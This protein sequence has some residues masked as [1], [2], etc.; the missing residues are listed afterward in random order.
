MPGVLSS[1]LQVEDKLTFQES[2]PFTEIDSFSRWKANFTISPKQWKILWSNFDKSQINY[3]SRKQRKLALGKSHKQ[4]HP[5]EATL[6]KEKSTPRL[7][8]IE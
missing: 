7:Q 5:S 3:K 2:E 8:N 1:T 4:T 6:S